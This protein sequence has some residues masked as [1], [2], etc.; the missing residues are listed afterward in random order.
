MKDKICDVLYGASGLGMIWGFIW[1]I[2]A[3][4]WL[5]MLAGSLIVG[6]VTMAVDEGGLK[7]EAVF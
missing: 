5:W 4:G 6:A 1:G 3:Q 2:F 7:H